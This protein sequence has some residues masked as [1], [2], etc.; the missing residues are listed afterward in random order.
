MKMY[1]IIL[2]WCLILHTHFYKSSQT[3][4]C[5]LLKTTLG[6]GLFG[7]RGSINLSIFVLCTRKDLLKFRCLNFSV[8]SSDGYCIY[9]ILKLQIHSV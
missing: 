4:V 8:L 1:L 5:F 7:Y 3:N 9:F 6:I 2:I